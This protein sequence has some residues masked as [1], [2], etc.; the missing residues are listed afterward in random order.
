MTNIDQNENNLLSRATLRRAA[1]A[2]VSNAINGDFPIDP[3]IGA[4]LSKTFSAVNS[5]VKRHGLLLQRT[6]GDA[7][8]A[9]GRFEV[10]SDVP[11]P[12]T[13]AAHDLLTSRNST[14]DLAKI[15]LKSDSNTVRMITLDLIVVDVEAG[16]AGGYDVKR[17][18]GA[19]ESRKR[20]PLEHDLRAARLVLSSFLGKYGYGDITNVTTGIID[21]YGSSGFD[22]ELRITKEGLDEH[23]G[24]PVLDTLEMMTGELQ[25]ALHSEMRGLL[26]PVLKVMPRT[27]RGMTGIEV[28]VGRV[29]DDE[30]CAD[31]VSRILSARP[32][33]PGP[34]RERVG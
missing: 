23:F 17:G 21:F 20:R 30:P 3:V 13:E 33:G 15:R 9:S 26:G 7:L 2:V 4:D 14:R 8:A 31:P 28:P 32:T 19:T 5:V 12:V 34:R 6:L 22:N 29:F 24:V 25:Q 27:E 11:V 10:M 16:W 18:N 1:R